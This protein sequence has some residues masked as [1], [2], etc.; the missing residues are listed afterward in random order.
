MLGLDADERFHPTDM[1]KAIFLGLQYFRNVP[2]GGIRSA[3]SL[4]RSVFIKG[5]KPCVSKSSK[6]CAAVSFLSSLETNEK[7]KQHKPQI[8]F[9]ATETYKAGK[10]RRGDV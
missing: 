9:I 10:D 4:F 2:S 5:F 8:T 3:L 7:Q 1:G 6:N